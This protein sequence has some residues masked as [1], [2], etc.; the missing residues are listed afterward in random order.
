M[1]QESYAFLYKY[2]PYTSVNDT[3]MLPQKRSPSWT[4][5]IRV[6]YCT[7]PW[8]IARAVISR[9]IGSPAN[10]DGICSRC[11]N[12][13]YWIQR[14]DR[15]S[16]KR[17]ADGEGAKGMQASENRLSKNVWFVAVLGLCERFAYYGII[18]MFRMSIRRSFIVRG[19]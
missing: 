7:V 14:I 13:C 15:G 1:V 19:T 10:S 5:W 8:P 17:E 18:V 4:T 12:A 6:F 16:S 3:Y 11:I 2:P 9:E